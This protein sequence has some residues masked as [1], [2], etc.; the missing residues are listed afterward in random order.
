MKQHGKKFRAAA[1]KVEAGRKYNLAEGVS[2]VK[3]I[4]FAKFDET[5]E[6]D[7]KRAQEN[8]SQ[9]FTLADAHVKQVLLIVFKLDP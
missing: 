5:V 1:E 6:P 8:R 9:E 7:A 2:K 3:E 4:A